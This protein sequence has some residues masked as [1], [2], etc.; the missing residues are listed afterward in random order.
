MKIII[1]YQQTNNVYVNKYIVI[2]Q[3]VLDLNIV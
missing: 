2:K 1:E 3:Q